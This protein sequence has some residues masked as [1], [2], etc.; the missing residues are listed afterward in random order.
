M[1]VQSIFLTIFI[2]HNRLTPIL[3]RTTNHVE[4]CPESNE[5]SQ[6]TVRYP[7]LLS[8]KLP[9]IFWSK[10]NILNL[11]IP[12]LWM[13]TFQYIVPPMKWQDYIRNRWL[14]NRSD[15][16][17]LVETLSSLKH[18][19]MISLPRDYRIFQVQFLSVEHAKKFALSIQKING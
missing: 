19:S 12:S 5:T 14:S 10:C 3:F 6:K 2:V 18:L 11:D 7:K 8:N 13:S 15:P 4:W 1:V 17:I 9:W 16:T